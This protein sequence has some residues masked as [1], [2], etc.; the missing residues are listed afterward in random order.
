MH[1]P[2]RVGNANTGVGFGSTAVNVKRLSASACVPSA[3]RWMN[4]TDCGGCQR[5]AS[6]LANYSKRSG[7]PPGVKRDGR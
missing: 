4:G 3:D 2:N 7:A 5:L 6:C 1:R